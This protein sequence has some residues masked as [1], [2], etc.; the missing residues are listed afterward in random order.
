LGLAS[1]GVAAFRGIRGEFE[2]TQSQVCIID[3]VKRTIEKTIDVQ[4]APTTVKWNDDGSLLAIG[5]INGAVLIDRYADL[6]KIGEVMER[7]RVVHSIRFISND[8]VAVA[9]E[10][11]V[12]VIWSL[13]AN[14]ALQTM[15]HNGLVQDFEI[16]RKRQRIVSISADGVAHGWELA[17]TSALT[18]QR[19]PGERFRFTGRGGI[20]AVAFDPESGQVALG[21]SSGNL[22]MASF[23]SELP[24]DVVTSTLGGINNAMAF[25][26]SSRIIAYSTNVFNGIIDWANGAERAR[27]I[28]VSGL[29]GFSGSVSFDIDTSGNGKYVVTANGD[30]VFLRST[31]AIDAPQRLATNSKTNRWTF[32]RFQGG[33]SR[34]IGAGA[35]AVAVWRAQPDRV[36][37]PYEL[38]RL[39]LRPTS[40]VECAV[41]RRRLGLA[42]RRNCLRRSNRDLLA[43]SVH[44]P[45][46]GISPFKALTVS[47]RSPSESMA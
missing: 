14:R 3:L 11:G 2:N 9:S 37:V 44:T 33:G 19:A 1:S 39:H 6:T 27:W 42:H 16:D 4:A 23:D 17:A 8:L 38:A 15:P 28:S 26:A 21:D 12:V 7:R 40:R 25:D 5:L 24:F 10:S 32:S 45:P 43:K 31:E 34:V 46:L 35:H 30:G 36:D 29:N 13:A 20:R 18:S 22:Y 41:H 47:I